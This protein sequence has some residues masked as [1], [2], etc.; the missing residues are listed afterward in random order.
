MKLR[1]DLTDT[2]FKDWIKQ[3]LNHHSVVLKKIQL[4]LETFVSDEELLAKV[5]LEFLK[6]KDLQ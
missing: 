2:D 5:E 1:T 4:L 6:R 3:E